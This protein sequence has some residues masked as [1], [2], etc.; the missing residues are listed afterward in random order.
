MSTHTSHWLCR[1]KLCRA[2]W[3]SP[4]VVKCQCWLYCGGLDGLFSLAV[5]SPLAPPGSDESSRNWHV[6]RAICCWLMCRNGLSAAARK[7][8]SRP[9]FSLHVAYKILPFKDEKESPPTFSL[10][11]KAWQAGKD[12]Q[13]G[14][15]FQKHNPQQPNCISSMRT[16]N[17]QTS[18]ASFSLCSLLTHVACSHRWTFAHWTST[19]FGG[20]IWGVWLW[21]V[22]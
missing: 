7:L 1:R 20:S 14:K 17:I 19:L 21:M 11:L 12:K 5:G 6:C 15:S 3:S 16:I 13:E 9:I 2:S 10:C 18:E 22:L 4:R 8:F